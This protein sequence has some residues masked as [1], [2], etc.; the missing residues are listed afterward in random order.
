LSVP[1]RLPPLNALRAFEAA[2][3]HGGFARAAD[4][5]AVTPAAVSQQVRLL[6]ADLDVTLFHRLPRGLVLTEAGRGALPDLSDA[7]AGLARAVEEMRGGSPA[8]PLVVS[9]LPS[10]AH[11]WLGPRLPGFAAAHPEVELTVRA[12]ARAVDFAR[13][14]VDVGVR[15]GR[16]VYPG[17]HVRLLLTE[18]VFPVCTPALAVGPPPLR[19][20]EDLRHHVL[21]HERGSPEPS[22]DWATWL[23]EAG[24]EGAGAARGPGFT[25]DAMLV[26]AA[27]RGM[28]VALG[29][30][31]LV[32]DE[33]AAGRLVR[34]LALARPAECAYYAVTREGRERHPRVRAF[35]GWLEGQA[36]AA[37]AAAAL[38]V[39][40]NDLG[41][42]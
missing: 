1:R 22:M 30:S 16:G 25:D 13:D 6:E 24:V 38:R 28:G 19:R 26:E 8:G 32:A 18:E 10:F 42:K 21:L 40:P 31:A 35:L 7:F 3:R 33:L 36:A 20:L 41:H 4:E 23:R 17:L 34:P 15:Y 14:P 27:V 39:S 12:E 11:R 37:R 2:A 5:L 9:V 29:R